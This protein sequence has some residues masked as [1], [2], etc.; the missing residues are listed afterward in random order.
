MSE[1][2]WYAS[3]GSNLLLER[4]MAYIRGG[5]APGA[6]FGQ[7]GCTDPTPPM[8]DKGIMIFHRLFFAEARPQWEDLG[9]AFIGTRKD[10]AARTLGR[11]YLITRDQFREVWLQENGHRRLDAGASPGRGRTLDLEATVRDGSS[12]MPVGLYSTLL[13]LG[14]E[15]GHPI[16]TFTASWNEGQAPINRP[17]PKYLGLIVRGL[18]ETFGLSNQGSVDYLRGVPGIRGVIS[19]KDLA[20]IVE[21]TGT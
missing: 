10:E 20:G 6:R 13:H 14:E 2:V 16:F 21:D 7:V 4:F 3:Y 17:G 12:R 11:M 18:K 19:E 9:V 5:K 1:H 15:G 8:E